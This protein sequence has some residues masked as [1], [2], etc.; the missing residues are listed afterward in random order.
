MLRCF[1]EAL[2]QEVER[3]GL[4]PKSMDWYLLYFV[5]NSHVPSFNRVIRDCYLRYL[6]VLEE[7]N[8]A[9][10]GTVSDTSGININLAQGDPDL[11]NLVA[12][13]VA[14]GDIFRELHYA[15][16]LKSLNTASKDTVPDTSS[17]DIGFTHEYSDLDDL[18]V[19]AVVAGDIFRYL[20][21]GL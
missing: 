5:K 6:E 20:H 11:D 12:R 19:R 16:A 7:M 13:A 21:R 9:R 4:E 14:A 18:V 2:K 10:Q 8:S 1:I 3:R 15:E 17:V